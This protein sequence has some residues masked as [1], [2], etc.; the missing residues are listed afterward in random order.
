MA[1]LTNKI[2]YR[3]KDICIKLCSIAIKGSNLRKRYIRIQR[4]KNRKKLA[5]P[6]K[7]GISYSVFD[8]EELL[9]HSLMSVRS[10][11]D[12][13]NVVY[14]KKSWYGNPCSE[15]LLDTL[16]SLKE[17][18]LIDELIEYIPD[19]N[20][21]PSVQELEK[22]NIGLRYAKLAKCNYFMTMDCDE[23]YIE[24]QMERAKKIITDMKIDLSYCYVVNYANLPT[25]RRLTPTPS[26]VQFFSKIDSRS[27]LALN[28][29]NIALVDP[30]RQL[31][32]NTFL[33]FKRNKRQYFLSGIEMHH[34]THF[35]KDFFKK[36][37]NS[38]SERNCNRANCKR[39]YKD[40]VVVP[41]CFGL[42]FLFD[43]D[44]LNVQK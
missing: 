29:E 6:L 35:R 10:Q 36:M 42:S 11:A 8:A 16:K 26:F 13:I 37:I 44:A 12:Y 34:M 40:T 17:K 5:V 25:L 1:R 33:C 7:W 31:S 2:K 22:R 4:H 14:Q 20:K 24:S 19:Y 18:G 21:A 32:E 39:E 27:V 38:S 15:N 9:E 28:Y 3:L 23:F 30:T 43:G 41:D